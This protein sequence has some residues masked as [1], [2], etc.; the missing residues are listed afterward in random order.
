MAF[1]SIDIIDFSLNSQSCKS[2]GGGLDFDLGAQ[3]VKDRW[4]ISD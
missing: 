4:D 3:G 2:V 1:K